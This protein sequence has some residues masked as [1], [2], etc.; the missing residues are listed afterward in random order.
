MLIKSEQPLVRGV[1]VL[2][3]GAGDPLVKE[4]LY[5][6]VRS[7]LGINASQIAIIEKERS[8]TN[9]IYR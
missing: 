5:L 1:A 9:E 4:R 3:E 2:A 6:A 7:L 8:E